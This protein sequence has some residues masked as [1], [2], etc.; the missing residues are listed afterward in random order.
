MCDGAGL[1]L[2]SSN[3]KGARARIVAYVETGG[4]PHASLTAGFTAMDLFWCMM[5]GLAVTGLLVWI[6]ELP[7]PQA[8]TISEVSVMGTWK[9]QP[10]GGTSASTPAPTTS[11]REQ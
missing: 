3:G 9:N 7:L 11:G 6:T 2:M 5:I 8:A 4:D 10:A 1:A